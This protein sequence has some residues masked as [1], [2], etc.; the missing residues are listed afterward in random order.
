MDESYFVYLDD[1]D[2]VY[3]VIK[4]KLK[5]FYLLIACM[6][7]KE[8]VCTGKKFDFFIHLFYRNREKFINK[9]SR[10]SKIG[11]FIGFVYVN[12]VMLF[13]MRTNIRQ[14]KIVK[15]AIKEGCVL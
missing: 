11:Y 14:W 10:I 3:R 9:H 15:T 5:I 2:F 12:T 6:E 8:S 13:K 1:T 4:N 7:Y